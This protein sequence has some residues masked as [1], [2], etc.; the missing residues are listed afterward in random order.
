LYTSSGVLV[1]SGPY[2]AFTG[3][4]EVDC[5][6]YVV[7]WGTSALYVVHRPHP[8]HGVEVIGISDTQLLVAD[9]SP[10]VRG[11]GDF[12]TLVL[13]DLAELDSL[14]TRL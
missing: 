4:S 14:A 12:D 3:C 11:T 9:S 7:D 6:V 5:D 2:I 13:L 1:V 10:D 8:D